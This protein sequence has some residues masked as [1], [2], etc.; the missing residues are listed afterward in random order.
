MLNEY[1]HQQYQSR[2]TKGCPLGSTFG[3]CREWQV[4]ISTSS[5]RYFSNAV[6]SGAL[7]DVWPP[8]TAPTL[9]AIISYNNW[10]GNTWSIC[11]DDLVD[12]FCFHGIE[13]Q[14]TPSRYKMSILNN[15]DRTVYINHFAIQHTC[16]LCLYPFVAFWTVASI[17]SDG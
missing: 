4:N 11:L 7:Q 14:I 13:N 16:K 1:L 12:I 2:G 10:T 8:T 5:G 6:I 9:V 17:D 15:V 3:P